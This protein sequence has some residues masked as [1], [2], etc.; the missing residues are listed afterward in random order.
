MEMFKIIAKYPTVIE[1]EMAKSLLET[2]GIESVVLDQ[3][4]MMNIGATISQWIRLQVRTE[5]FD[6]A[7]EILQIENDLGEKFG[8]STKITNFALALFN[9]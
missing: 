2:H 7:Y 1:A 4:M 3:N 6:K 5:D 8:E 9:L